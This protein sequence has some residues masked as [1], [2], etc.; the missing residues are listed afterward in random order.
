MGALIQYPDYRILNTESSI[1]DTVY[2]IA[3]RIQD[4]P[5]SHSLVSPDKQAPA[6]DGKRLDIYGHA[7]DVPSDSTTPE[8]EGGMGGVGARGCAG[9]E[10]GRMSFLVFLAIFLVLFLNSVSKL[11]LDPL[12]LVFGPYVGTMLGAFSSFFR[13]QDEVLS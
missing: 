3:Y 5:Y 11:V 1:Q 4:T 8:G 7:M 10:G 9:H 12:G 6:D 13:S 2:R